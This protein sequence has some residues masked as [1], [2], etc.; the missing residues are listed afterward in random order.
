MTVTMM[1]TKTEEF[2]G[3]A[4]RM[5]NIKWS[6]HSPHDNP[7]QARFLLDFGL[8]AMYGGAA[9]GGK[10]DALLMAALQFVDVPGYA[11]ILF[12]KTFPDLTLPGALIDRSHDW[13]DRTDAR[14][15]E[16]EHSWTFPSGA[17]L[18]FGYLKRDADTKRYQSAEFQFIGFD[19]LTQFA[20]QQYTYLF[21]RLRAP[22][23][24]LLARIPL[25]MRAASNPGGQGHAWVKRRF[26]DGAVE[27]SDGVKRSGP[28]RTFHPARLTDNPFL[29]PEEYKRSLSELGAVDLAQLLDGDWGVTSKGGYFEKRWFLSREVTRLPARAVRRVRYWDIGSTEETDEDTDPDWSASALMSLMPSG[30]VVLENVTRLRERPA[31]VERAAQVVAAWDPPGTEIYIEQEPGASGKSLVSYYRRHV[32]AEYPVK[33]FPRSK[34]KE[35]FARP[36]SARAEQ[37]DVLVLARGATPDRPEEA[38]DLGILAADWHDDFYD[39]AELFPNGAH[40]DM[41]DAVTGAFSVLVRNRLTDAAHGAPEGEPKLSVWRI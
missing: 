9:G 4:R 30:E 27:M 3:L 28:N 5:L 8:E 22:R 25:R 35:A 37:G 12:R 23:K 41:V 33:P 18:Q 15:S 11:A 40:D 7:K 1:P 21:S 38:R 36:V 29:D 17:V 31:M 20:E 13:L 14:W 6:P 16:R 24:G 19:E 34:S 10:S 32:L 39:E 2:A 26:V